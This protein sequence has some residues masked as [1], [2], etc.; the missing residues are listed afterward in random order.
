M[1]AGLHDK[2]RKLRIEN[3]FSQKELSELLGMSPS[4]ISGYETGEKTPSAEVLLKLTG[5]YHCSADYL[6]GLTNKE[7]PKLIDVTGLTPE[8]VKS[9][10]ILI[11]AIKKR[12]L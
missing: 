6:L 5:L 4:V 2:L 3:N 11:N 9:L 10:H 12:Q 8:Q 7:E 1:I